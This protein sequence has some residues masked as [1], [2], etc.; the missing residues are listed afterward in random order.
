MDALLTAFGKE[1]ANDKGLQETADRREKDVDQVAQR[2]AARAV[3][4]LVRRSQRGLDV[5]KQISER[6][7]RLNQRPNPRD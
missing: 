2:G 1:L 5:L 7:D 3:S 4:S 6:A